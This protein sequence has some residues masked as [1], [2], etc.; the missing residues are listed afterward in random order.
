MV[1]AKALENEREVVSQQTDVDQS[2]SGDEGC[3]VDKGKGTSLRRSDRKHKTPPPPKCEGT[4]RG[5]PKPTSR[6]KVQSKEPHLKPRA[7]PEPRKNLPFSQI[8]V[9]LS[10]IALK[11]LT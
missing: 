2:N 4:N 8:L 6:K 5:R 11:K 7:K 9:A 10:N 1:R 3:D